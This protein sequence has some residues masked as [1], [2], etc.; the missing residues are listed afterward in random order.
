MRLVRI[1]M[2]IFSE[3]RFL[4]IMVLFRAVY[5]GCGHPKFK[6]PAR[7]GHLFDHADVQLGETV[8]AA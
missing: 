6:M 1:R 7:H 2:Q 8:V 3:Y 4:P 5:N